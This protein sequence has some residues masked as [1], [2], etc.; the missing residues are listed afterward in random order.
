MKNILPQNGLKRALQVKLKK[1]TNMTDEEWDEYE[2]K[3][4]S[5]I[6]LALH[7]DVMYNVL[8]EKTTSGIWAKQKSIYV[9][10]SLTNKLFLKRQL[11]SLKMA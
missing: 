8:K 1:P 3:V 4:V 7:Q 11:Y 10:K 9:S 2:Q 6:H 5:S